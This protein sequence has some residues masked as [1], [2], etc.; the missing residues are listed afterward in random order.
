[1]INYD[2]NKCAIVKRRKGKYEVYLKY[3]NQTNPSSVSD[4][5]TERTNIFYGKRM[6]N[7]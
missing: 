6:K 7:N 4:P 1:M 2:E 3:C 5:W